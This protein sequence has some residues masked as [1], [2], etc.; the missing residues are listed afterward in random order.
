MKRKIA[1]LVFP[2]VALVQSAF[3]VLPTPL[4]TSPADGSSG[5]P[6][7]TII[8][9]YNVTGANSYE[10]KI[11]T[12]PALAGASVQSSTSSQYA[13]SQLLYGTTY[14][15]QVRA[16]K[17]TGTPDSSAWT[18]IFSFATTNSLNITA[19]ANGAINQFPKVFLNWSN[20]GGVSNYQVQ[21]D[22]N[23]SFN[24]PSLIDSL[25]PDTS[26]DCYTNSLQFGTTYYWRARGMH[27]LDT[28]D[29]SAVYSFTVLDGVSLSDPLNG[30]A[31][32]SPGVELNWDYISG[33][34]NY[35]VQI[36]ELNSFSSPSLLS[37]IVPD[38]SSNWTPADLKFGST[39]YWRV[40]TWHATDTSQWSAVWDFTTVSAL[41]LT[42]P[43]DNSSNQFPNVV[44]NWNYLTDPIAYDVEFDTT[45]SFNS[46]L[47][48]YASN[49]T[50]SEHQT[51]ELRF[52]TTYYWRARARTAVDTSQWSSIWSFTTLDYLNLTTPANNAT[53]IPSRVTLNWS[54]IS[55]V[56][57]YDVRYD[58]TSNF[59]SPLATTINTGLSNQ[60]ISNLYFGT[61]YYWS[62]RA[63]HPADASEW[64]APYQ[65]TTTN[66]VNL[67]SPLNGSS[68]ATP[69][70][71]LNWSN[72]SGSTA[73]QVEYD[74]SASL[75]SPVYAS[76]T[77]TTSN[78]FVNNLFFNQVYYWR[79]RAINAVDTSDWSPI[80][81]F[82]TL[83][84]LVHTS[85]LDGATGQALLTEINWAGV[86]GAVGYIYRFD[87]SPLFNVSPVI[88]NSVGTNSRADINLT[89]YGQ[90]Y[91][92]QVA[93]FDSVDTSGWSNPWSFTTI[94]Q[95]N[96]PNLISPS[97][98]SIGTAQNN[99]G[100]NWNAVNS[101]LSYEM[102]YSLDST[103]SS[104]TVLTTNDTF[105]VASGLASFTTYYWRVRA[106]NAN[107]YSSWSIIYSFQTQNPFVATPVLFA[108][109]DL[110]VD[111][112]QPVAFTWY[113]L[114]PASSYICEYSLDAGFS[115]PVQLTTNDTVALSNTLSPLTTYYWRVRGVDGNALSGWSSVWSFTTE[116]PLTVAPLQYAP[117]DAATAIATPANFQ[118]YSIALAASY[119]CEYDTDSLFSSPV[120]L[121][122]ND[123]AVVS[124]P[125]NPFTTYFWR[126]RGVL[127]NVG[128]PWSSTWKFTSDD[129]TIPFPVYPAY[130]D[131]GLPSPVTFVW[132]QVVVA[133]SY[134]LEYDTDSLF[135][136]PIV[137][138]STSDTA[139]S[140]NLALSTK[141]FWRVRA[142]DGTTFYNWSSVW[143][144]TTSFTVGVKSITLL[145]PFS[146]YPNPA[147][148]VVNIS[149]ALSKSL[150]SIDVYSINGQLYFSKQL[151]GP[152]N[153][154][155]MIADW[156][157]G[158]Y[159]ILIR[160]DEKQFM[161][162]L[163][164]E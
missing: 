154:Q 115:N 144:F 14:Y 17:T 109:E 92:W 2:F 155:L 98:L 83:N 79:V 157:K 133:T 40:R 25:R 118:W 6:A 126:V 96:A 87:I 62:A 26:S 141:Y 122:A 84:S 64:A 85:P 12:D 158:I 145:T 7:N 119:E 94:Y 68:G 45:T 42:S 48:T 150:T 134:Q 162:K 143:H 27:A 104:S 75:N 73:Y 137:L 36:D 153:E 63:Y 111:V 81:S 100:F 5:N 33:V 18:Q 3:A 151:Q 20:S 93:V 159:A 11:N 120:T 50:I 161:H 10:F 43:A 29:W 24:S 152:V 142:Y 156:P 72:L 139:Q 97:N 9:W 19:P 71:N 30:S 80:W 103:F 13:N 53:A 138:T 149:S 108:P 57:G 114:A 66:T 21:W 148:N 34:T 4:I 89:Q 51:S 123:T 35:Q 67:T 8:N 146:I 131:T 129:A 22:D 147:K 41:T 112:P 70:T 125:L 38:S 110:A 60:Q 130:A 86:S 121:I 59:S 61:T 1:K 127:G 78:Y 116:N 106:V 105:T 39:Y 164:V 99:L 107:G 90:T 124:L 132:N 56:S 23:I 16:L 91:Y 31:F 88:G 160:V 163:I 117:A 136:N 55:G 52:G 77:A 28:M 140:Q 135:S 49:D 113:P 76:A 46:P 44:L 74:T 69:R 82:T 128:S 95:L 58:T 37:A 65:F 102:E 47:Y 32:I 15:W 54:Y 101:A